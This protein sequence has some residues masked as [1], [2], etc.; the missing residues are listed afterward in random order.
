MVA[1]WTIPLYAY[2]TFLVKGFHSE[3]NMKT[4]F[5]G[6][7]ISLGVNV[8]ISL[9]LMEKMGVLGL[10][11]ANLISGLF[12]MFFLF[13]KKQILSFSDWFN[14]SSFSIC[15]PVVGCIGIYF[16]LEFSLPHFAIFDGKLADLIKLSISV[17]SSV[18][19][20][21]LILKILKFNW[22][23]KFFRHNGS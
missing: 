4:P 10:A 14:P 8:C 9:L 2:T 23:L 11:W 1:A 22:G 7:L 3:K 13:W 18:F 17:F 19:V 21:F 5:Y 20:Y 6:A 16:F 15:S 12:Q